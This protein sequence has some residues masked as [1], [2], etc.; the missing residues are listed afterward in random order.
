MIPAIVITLVA[1]S[2]IGGGLVWNF[3]GTMKE[4]GRMEVSQE[5]SRATTVETAKNNK[6]VQKFQIERYKTKE[7]LK[8]NKD[9][10]EKDKAK[11]SFQMFERK[12]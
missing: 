2:L 7:E 4:T 3:G 6:A 12:P 8:Y 9:L 5:V 1:G 11:K 10:S